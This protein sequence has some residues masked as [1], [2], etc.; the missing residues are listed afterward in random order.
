MEIPNEVLWMTQEAVWA[1]LDRD[2]ILQSLAGHFS[3]PQL[4]DAFRFMNEW[5]GWRAD[6]EDVVQSLAFEES[7]L[8]PCSYRGSTQHL[9]ATSTPNTAFDRK[10]E[11]IT[12][13]MVKHGRRDKCEVSGRWKLGDADV[14]EDKPPDAA[15]VTREV[16]ALSLD[17]YWNTSNSP[18]F[19]SFHPRTSVEDTRFP[20]KSS[21]NSTIPLLIPAKVHHNLSIDREKEGEPKVEPAK[22]LVEVETVD[23]SLVKL[24]FRFE[25][26]EN[27][28]NLDNGGLKC[29]KIKRCA[30]PYVRVSF[31]GSGAD[32]DPAS[33]IN[34][35]SPEAHLRAFPPSP[36]GAVSVHHLCRSPTPTHDTQDP[37]PLQ[38]TDWFVLEKKNIA[39]PLVTLKIWKLMK[40]FWNE[41]PEFVSTKAVFGCHASKKCMHKEVKSI[42]R[43]LEQLH[44]RLRWIT[45]V[46]NKD[47]RTMC[48][49]DLSVEDYAFQE[50][51]EHMKSW[52][53]KF[54]MECE[55]IGFN[56]SSLS[57]YNLNSTLT[58]LNSSTVS[59]CSEAVDRDSLQQSCKTGQVLD[60]KPLF[61]EGN[62]EDCPTV[63]KN[64][65]LYWLWQAVNSDMD[66]ELIVHFTASHY[67]LQEVH[68]SRTI[69]ASY[70]FS[71]SYMKG[72]R[73]IL[74]EMLSALRSVINTQNKTIPK[75]VSVD[76]NNRPS[77]RPMKA[78][79]IIKDLEV[80]GDMAHT[81]TTKLSWLL[82][83]ARRYSSAME[84]ASKGTLESHLSAIGNTLADLKTMLDWELASSQHGSG[85]SV[86]ETP[87]PMA[88]SQPAYMYHTRTS[89]VTRG[90][91]LQ[92][93][94]AETTG[95]YWPG[96]DGSIGSWYGVNMGEAKMV[97]APS[98][99]LLHSTYP[100]YT[101]L[102][103]KHPQVCAHTSRHQHITEQC[104]KVT[105]PQPPQ[106][107]WIPL[108]ESDRTKPSCIFTV[109]CY[110]V[111]CDK[112]A[113][114]QMYGYCPSWALEWEY[115]KKGIMDEIKHYLADI[116]TLQEVET[117]QFFNFF[118]PELKNDGYDG[119][120]S[121]K[122]RAK[123]MSENERKY[124][125]GCAI[126]WRTSKFTLVKERLI[127]FN[128]LAMANHDGSEDMLNRVMTKDNIGL[129]ALLETKE[130]AWENTEVLPDKSQVNQS[131]LVC[132]AHI[133]WD[134]EF[135]DVKLI[136][137]IML[138]SE[139]RQ[140]IGQI[141]DES[142]HRSRLG[143]KIDPGSI[144]LL[145]CGDLNSLPD[146]G[147]VEFLTKGSVSMDHEDFKGFGYKT[148]LQ[149]IAM[150]KNNNSLVNSSANIY[151]H[152]YRLSAAY[153]FAIMAYTNYT[154]DFKGI[155]DYIFH[156]SDTMSSLG[157]L[158]PIDP[159]WFRE[160]KVMG[161]PHP[162]IPSG[163]KPYVY[164][165]TLV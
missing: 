12:P 85:A 106:R 91:L 110:N 19:E 9:A 54:F 81:M 4:V 139:I 153:D 108:T 73:G 103:E 71:L 45:P 57:S 1:S 114:R 82:P 87:V 10:T 28:E 70:N 95:G 141:V 99:T 102:R 50:A 5:I 144:Q 126:F 79:S 101:S 128:Q 149:K 164:M 68:Q 123:H 145:L 142:Q 23:H 21:A 63:I 76:V 86:L 46:I 33:P 36:C 84:A 38:E 13:V 80:L 3:I 18:S 31:S 97:V 150:T 77:V 127:E 157:V 113:T 96:N 83:E 43:L 53:V 7:P 44:A 75:F 89:D 2:D 39:V 6:R 35:C 62:L 165:S 134:P 48:D 65:L 22:E 125:D 52:L 34:K 162:H 51:V 16:A 94:E 24:A 14:V 132:T 120:F 130:A 49:H 135:C 100:P 136:Q 140:I 143:R 61:T 8:S 122:S 147:V 109:M 151:T 121:P 115:R 105:T 27:L 15:V 64:D 98:N 133:H 32:D 124:V 90:G 159:D 129:A 152:N 60:T 88:C 37:E 25:Q 156:S 17:E 155:I 163:K 161:C 137:T 42:N 131:V 72:V 119:I 138:M 55:F 78:S 146:S 59:T 69:L 56:M 74:F 40:N 107:P 118:L 116:I 160:N 26:L 41:L 29:Y 20:R 154:Y 66:E 117:D 30:T 158:G 111:L 104:A 112:Y 47:C 67:S 148:C 58:V 92:C 11:W 93:T